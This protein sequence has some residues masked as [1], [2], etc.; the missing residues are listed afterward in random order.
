LNT[1]TIREQRLSRW[2]EEYGNSILKICFIYLADRSLAEDATQ[3]TFLKAWKNISQFEKRNKCSEKS[4]LMRIAI[5]TCHDYH[6]TRW[7]RHMDM[8]RALEDLPESMVS[9]SEFDRT[10]FL[11]IA[12]LPEKY[13]QVILLRYYQ[14][15]T[16]EET[17]SALQIG[18]SAVNYRL[19]KA[20][21]MLKIG[22]REEESL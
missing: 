10:L 21:Q 11:D 12:A 7:F 15:M 16:I 8:R 2:I 1:D 22:W 14:D 19:R 17:A 20:L 4:W 5:N 6:R 13:K 18:P 9:V 3:D